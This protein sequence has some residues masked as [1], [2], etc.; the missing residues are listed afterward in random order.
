MKNPDRWSSAFWLIF[1]LFICVES[2]RLDIGS[3]HNP[4]T[5]FFPFLAGMVFGIL[6]L[7]LFVLTLIRK[8]RGAGVLEKVQW[9][10]IVLVLISLFVYA[11]V[12]E[13]LGFILSNI[14]FVAALLRIIERKKWVLVILVAVTSTLAFYVV[15]QL[16][17]KS[18][19][20]R[21]ILGI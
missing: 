20:P 18:Q 4:G 1:S 15:F 7:V 19:L 2:Y 11:I 12:L 13:E 10:S 5:G 3:F 21:G 9:K 6:S 8:R 14:L 16:W 17:L